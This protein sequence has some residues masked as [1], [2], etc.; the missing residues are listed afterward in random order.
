M[1]LF[2]ELQRRNVLRVAIAYIAVSWLL[3]Q[4]AGALFPLYGLTDA[5]I[6]LVVAILGVGFIPAIVVSWVF[7]LTPEGYRQLNWLYLVGRCRFPLGL[8]LRFKSLY[9]ASRTQHESMVFAVEPAGG[10]EWKPFR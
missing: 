1:S 6:R 4:V 7:E 10:T 8:G 3:I 2:A 5:A 9:C